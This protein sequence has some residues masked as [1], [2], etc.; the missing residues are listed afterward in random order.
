ME[1]HTAPSTMSMVVVVAVE[2]LR[3]L[4]YC[5]DLLTFLSSKLEENVS[6]NSDTYAEFTNPG[7]IA[8]R[9]LPRHSD[10]V[11]RVPLC[12]TQT[13]NPSCVSIKSITE[14]VRY[15]SW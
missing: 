14:G 9:L 4:Q 11:S 5:F 6:P 12:S 1:S 3:L 2:S 8:L 7:P 15:L 10:A 13:T